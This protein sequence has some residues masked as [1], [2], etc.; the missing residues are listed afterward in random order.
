M[1][2]DDVKKPVSKEVEIIRRSRRNSIV[3]AKEAV[4]GVGDF[5]KERMELDP[6]FPEAVDKMALYLESYM[7]PSEHTDN[8]PIPYLSQACGQLLS[9]DEEVQTQLEQLKKEMKSLVDNGQSKTAALAFIEARISINLDSNIRSHGPIVEHALAMAKKRMDTGDL[10]DVKGVPKWAKNSPVMSRRRRS[11]IYVERCD[12]LND[13]VSKKHTTFMK[14]A[15]VALAKATKD[16]VFV[17]SRCKR[18]IYFCT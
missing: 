5:V 1:K 14:K 7:A 2:K 3:L 16:P 17:L 11:K 4:D 18:R 6:N 8:K 10:G 15:N 12:Q 13:A 9:A